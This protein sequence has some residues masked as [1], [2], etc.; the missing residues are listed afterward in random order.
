MTYSLHFTASRIGS[1][2]DE[3]P[4]DTVPERYYMEADAAADVAESLAARLPGADADL[5]CPAQVSINGWI[6]DG[7]GSLNVSVG[8]IDPVLS[9]G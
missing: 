5:N 1:I 3:A 4:L 8:L 6:T 9:K 7:G 2:H